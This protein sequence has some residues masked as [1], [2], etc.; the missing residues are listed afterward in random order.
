MSNLLL[1]AYHLNKVDNIEHNIFKI[2]LKAL[3]HICLLK[4][5]KKTYF[6]EDSKD[7][8]TV[9]F[10]TDLMLKDLELSL[11]LSVVQFS[12]FIINSSNINLY[13]FKG[14]EFLVFKNSS[15]PRFVIE[16]IDN[17]NYSSSKMLEC[18]NNNYKIYAEDFFNHNKILSCDVNS[19][20]DLLITKIEENIYN[21]FPSVLQLKQQIFESCILNHFS[22][23]REYYYKNYKK[24]DFENFVKSLEK[25]IVS[26]KLEPLILLYLC[27]Y[28]TFQGH[29]HSK[30]F[31]LFK[32]KD[33]K[34]KLNHLGSLYKYDK[35]Y[36]EHLYLKE[37]IPI[38][39]ITGYGIIDC[40]KIKK[41]QD[42][43]SYAMNNKNQ[44][45][46]KKAGNER[47]SFQR[48]IIFEI[49]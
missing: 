13:I 5:N 1:K 9:E 22:F 21:N 36:L 20:F 6:N 12:H 34:F 46:F 19:Y 8:K 42:S 45:T 48:K 3:K 31:A 43:Y 23:R 33:F 18:K 4:V 35:R 41:L 26:T 2:S 30:L 47:L 37:K 40:K 38:N 15:N 49:M 17:E 29:Y 7:F 44:I 27:Y 28:F 11:K 32:F 10:L 14:D 24:N 16:L 25:L 39:F